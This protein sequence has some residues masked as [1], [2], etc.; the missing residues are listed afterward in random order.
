MKSN[1]YKT[2]N[3]F[4]SNLSNPLRINIISFLKG[5]EM[6]V[7]ELSERLGVEQSKLSHALAGL[8]EC[9]LVK[10]KQNG[11]K[12]I[13]SLNKKTLI[14]ILKIIDKHAKSYCSCESCSGCRQ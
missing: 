10:V 2:Y 5:K 14:P 13:Y 11:K 6:C 12:R 9:N 4:F 3:T 8:K 1:S 7:N